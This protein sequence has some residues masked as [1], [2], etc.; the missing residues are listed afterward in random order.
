MVMGLELWYCAYTGWNGDGLVRS[1][2]L[3]GEA[4]FAADMSR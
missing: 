1:Q 3:F 4:S 2:G